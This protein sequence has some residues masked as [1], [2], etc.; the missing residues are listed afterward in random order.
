MTMPSPPGV[1]S[2]TTGGIPS[3]VGRRSATVPTTEP[4][5]T[6]SRT[7]HGTRGREFPSEP[8]VDERSGTRFDHGSP[9]GWVRDGGIRPR[10]SGQPPRPGVRPRDGVRRAP[11]LLRVGRLNHSDVLGS[12]TRCSRSLPWW[13]G[14]RISKPPPKPGRSSYSLPSSPPSPGSSAATT[15]VPTAGTPASPAF[16]VR[17][18]SLRFTETLH[19]KLASTN[20]EGLDTADFEESAGLP[21]AKDI[22]FTLTMTAPDVR[23]VIAEP[24]SAMRAAGTIDSALLGPEPVPVDN[25]WFR[26]FVRHAGAPGDAHMTYTLPVKTERGPASRPDGVQDHRTRGARRPLAWH[27]DVV[28]QPPLGQP[29][30]AGRRARRDAYPRR[31]LRPPTLDHAGHWSGQPFRASGSARQVR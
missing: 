9:P 22:A 31:G 7:P 13:N 15:S 11:W 25:G 4:R 5:T 17:V 16:P 10:W 21:D 26:L 3:S 12:R 29:H 18:P 20:E 8:A 2:S 14:R 23:T 19:G 28:R 30:G 24:Q 1:S 27:D 6:S